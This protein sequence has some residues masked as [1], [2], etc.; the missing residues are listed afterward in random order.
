MGEAA[1][2]LDDI[3]VHLRVPEPQQRHAMCTPNPL[4]AWPPQKRPA[5]KALLH[6]GALLGVFSGTAVCG[7]PTG[8]DLLLGR[9][10]P[11]RAVFAMARIECDSTSW[12]HILPEVVCHHGC[13]G[14]PATRQALAL[15]KQLPEVLF[16]RLA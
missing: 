14:L 13:D 15:L 9:L 4:Q 2:A 16:T 1:I 10:P 12:R 6:T 11:L 7:F 5:T 3:P 8:S